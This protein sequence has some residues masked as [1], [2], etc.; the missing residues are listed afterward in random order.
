MI[1]SMT[2]RPCSL[3]YSIRYII[4]HLSSPILPSKKNKSSSTCHLIPATLRA[5]PLSPRS[6]A[7]TTPM[8]L[9]PARRAEEIPTAHPTHLLRSGPRLASPAILARLR[10][11]PLSSRSIASATPMSLCLARRAEEIPTAHPTQLLRSSPR[12]ASPAILATLRVIPLSPRSIASTTPMSLCPARRAEEIEIP[13]AHPTY[14]TRLRS[15]PRLASPAQSK[16]MGMALA[17][18]P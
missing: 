10:V 12:L 1:S 6:I 5:I 13:T 3:R 16:R 17:M 4:P 9:C 2:R 14:P 8:S 7:S 18:A 11:I 15:G